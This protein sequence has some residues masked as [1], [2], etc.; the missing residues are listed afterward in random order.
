MEYTLRELS[1]TLCLVYNYK[2]FEINLIGKP[3]GFIR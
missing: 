1:A 2:S 3:N